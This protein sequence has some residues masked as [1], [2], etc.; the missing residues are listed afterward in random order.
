MWYWIS[1]F[2]ILFLAAYGNAMRKVTFK[3]RAR[4]EAGEKTIGTTPLYDFVGLF[5]QVGGLTA[6]VVWCIWVG[7]GDPI[8]F[9]R[10]IMR[11]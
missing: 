11:G 9:I 1:V 2:V 3:R 5:L 10:D 4:K 8:T 7:Y 6:L